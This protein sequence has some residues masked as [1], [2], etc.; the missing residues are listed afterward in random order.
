MTPSWSAVLQ[1]KTDHLRQLS[2]EIEVLA[3]DAIMSG[4]A[5]NGDLFLELEETALAARA[6]AES[7]WVVAHNERQRRAG[8]ADRMAGRPRDPF[9]AKAGA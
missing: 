6:V 1:H 7:L 3:R 4:D 2:V 5:S 8:L 9:L